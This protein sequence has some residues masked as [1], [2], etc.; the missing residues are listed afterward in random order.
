L[1]IFLMIYTH[2]YEALGIAGW[3]VWPI[4]MLGLAVSD[5]INHVFP[6]QGEGW[7]EGLGTTVLVE[8]AFLWLWIWILLMVIVKLIEKF[9][10][11]KRRNA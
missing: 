4:V 7:F 5:W 2:A 1:L 8:A 3:I 6:P 10:P 9:I 11:R